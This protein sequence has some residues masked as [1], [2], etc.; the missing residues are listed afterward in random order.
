MEKYFSSVCSYTVYVIAMSLGEKAHPV[1][2]KA[3]SE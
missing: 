3:V 1:G 2:C